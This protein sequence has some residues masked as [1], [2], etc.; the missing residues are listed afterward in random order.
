MS[1]IEG[2]FDQYV[3]EFMKRYFPDGAYPE[4]CV[5]AL[6]VAGIHLL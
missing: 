5:R 2:R 1:I 4:W 3:K 6:D